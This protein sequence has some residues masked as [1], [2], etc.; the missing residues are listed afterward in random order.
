MIT[1]DDPETDAACEESLG[2]VEA[3]PRFSNQGFTLLYVVLVCLHEHGL[4]DLD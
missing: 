1:F 4:A 3:Y 2:E